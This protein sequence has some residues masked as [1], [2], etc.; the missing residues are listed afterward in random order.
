MSWHHHGEGV[1]AALK[2]RLSRL[3]SIKEGAD[4]EASHLIES[5]E[6]LLPLLE[7]HIPWHAYSEEQVEHARKLAK[8][9]NI[10]FVDARHD[11]T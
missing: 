11:A 5:A 10:D 8:E 3:K 7:E 2:G 6:K 4:G 1:V 9:M